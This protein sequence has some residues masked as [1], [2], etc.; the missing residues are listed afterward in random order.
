MLDILQVPP[1][2][3]DK[4]VLGFPLVDV[5]N[6][7]ASKLQLVGEVFEHFNNDVR[8]LSGGN[9]VVEFMVSGDGDSTH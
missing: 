1:Q 6:N 8:L 2:P 4:G 5:K 7:F 9:G 3:C